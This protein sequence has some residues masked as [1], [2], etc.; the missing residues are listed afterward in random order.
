M[1]ERLEEL[2]NVLA[3]HPL[4]SRFGNLADFS[5]IVAQAPLFDFITLTDTVRL[6]DRI[7]RL[8]ETR[9]LLVHDM[10]QIRPQEAG[11]IPWNR[12]GQCPHLLC[13]CPPA[14]T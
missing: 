2:L 11:A 3:S 14:L 4:T 13:K 6:V 1:L 5:S 10:E 12:D 7:A 9:L 8:S